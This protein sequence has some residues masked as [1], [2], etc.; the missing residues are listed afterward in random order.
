MKF[1]KANG[2]QSQLT[3]LRRIELEEIKKMPKSPELINTQTMITRALRLTATDYPDSLGSYLN[4]RSKFRADFNHP[5]NG[6]V[7][8]IAFLM[9]DA[10]PNGISIGDEDFMDS[11]Q[12]I[13]MGFKDKDDTHFGIDGCIDVFVRGIGGYMLAWDHVRGIGITPFDRDGLDN[14]IVEFVEDYFPEFAP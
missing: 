10:K 2:I 14:E 1:H 13:R 8:R 12:K 3:E 7:L 9:D 11:V 5:V 6:W 4:S